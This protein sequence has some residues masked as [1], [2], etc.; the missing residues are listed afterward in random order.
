MTMQKTY[1]SVVETAELVRLALK[2]HFPGIKFSVRSSTY[3]GGSAID[4]TWAFGPTA[5][6][7][8][9]ILDQYESADFDGMIDLETHK[10]HWLLPDGSTLV[11]QAAGTESSMGVIPAEDNPPPEGAVPVQFAAHYVQ[12]QRRLYIKD[13]R[14]ETKLVERVAKAMCELNHAEWNGP[15]Q[16]VH[17]FGQGDT[18]QAVQHAWRLLAMTSF[19]PGEEYSSVRWATDAEREDFEVNRIG[20]VIVKSAITPVAAGA[21][22]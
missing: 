20:M 4:V 2:K 16:T 13:Y 18:E 17:L 21:R 9:A 7:V 3:S 6:E 14:E 1:Y 10:S 11:R 8:Q 5:K 19:K 22:R 15:Q 12:G